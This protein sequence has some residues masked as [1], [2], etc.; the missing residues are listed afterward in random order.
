MDKQT[1]IFCMLP[2]SILCHEIHFH[3]HH[4]IFELMKAKNNDYINSHHL[5]YWEQNDISDSVRGFTGSY[6]WILFTTAIYQNFYHVVEF[7]MKSRNSDDTRRHVTRANR[8][9]SRS[10]IITCL[11]AKQQHVN[12]SIIKKSNEK[13]KIFVNNMSSLFAF[14]VRD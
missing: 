6:L 7:L 10:T 13:K 1:E 9:C 11:S 12:H 8:C 5:S 2:L 14:Q 4:I 3:F